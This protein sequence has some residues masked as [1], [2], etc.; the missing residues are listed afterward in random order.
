MVDG[1]IEVREERARSIH[2]LQKEE[3]EKGRRIHI[4]SGFQ[5]RSGVEDTP[6]VF[7]WLFSSR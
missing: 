5:N 7:L 2:V 3:D 1:K 4:W 6:L